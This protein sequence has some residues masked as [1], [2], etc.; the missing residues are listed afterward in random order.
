M[1]LI[2]KNADLYGWLLGYGRLCEV[3]EEV[4]EVEEVSMRES[5]F[6]LVSEKEV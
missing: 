2:R 4:V 6:G 3:P 5:G 1:I